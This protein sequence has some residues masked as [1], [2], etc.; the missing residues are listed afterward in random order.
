MD[1]AKGAA[2][3]GAAKATGAAAAA[4]AAASGAKAE[5]A[6]AVS[7]AKAKVATARKKVMTAEQR[8]MQR[9]RARNRVCNRQADARDLSGW[10]RRK[11]KVACRAKAGFY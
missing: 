5:A 9:W 3:A 1:A 6:K 7:G 10:P 8:Y 2:A 4:G 11:F